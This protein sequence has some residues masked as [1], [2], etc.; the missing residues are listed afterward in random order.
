V[1]LSYTGQPSMRK[2]IIVSLCLTVL[3][4]ITP[5]QQTGAQAKAP[6]LSPELTRQLNAIRDTALA[7]DYA[8]RQVAHLTENIGPRPV[9]SPQA[10]A[11]VEY[12]AGQLRDLGLEV[13]LEEVRAPRWV[14]GLETAE[15]VDYPGHVPGVVQKI[16]VT[17]LGGNHPTANE[18]I[19]AEVLVVR[20]SAELE[21]LGGRSVAGKIVL[22][23]VPFDK[24]KAAAGF[25][26]EAYDEAVVYRGQGAV[27]AKALGA[28]AALVRSVG[29]AD[30]RIPHT[31][32]SR[33]A[34]IPAGAVSAEDADLIAHLSSQGRVRIHLTLTGE[35][36]EDV[37][38][39]NVIGDLKG[40]E[41][42]EQIVIVSGHLDSW[43]LGTGAIDDA[44]GVAVAMQAAHILK[45]LNLHPRRTLRVIA[46][47]DE[48]NFGRGHEAYARAHS[49]E[50]DNHMAA[51]ESDLG[52]GHP[53]GV[54]AKIAMAARERVKPVLQILEPI[55]ANILHPE[56][57]SPGA[58]IEPLV[59]AGVPG[60][61]ILQDSRTYF[62]YHHTP[63][64]TLG[65][66]VP[67]EL[68]ENAVV[69][70]VL[71]YALAEMPEPLPRQ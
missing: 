52:A 45:Q 53:M 65:K 50:M 54:D 16:V 29:G 46:W 35:S 49:A 36:K 38:T 61:G 27:R 20:S 58:D 6:A 66:I 11:A 26:N 22:F 68:Q 57:G 4:V 60:F 63:A 56:E 43:D 51:I 10:N 48:E 9:G 23:N 67:R 32:G 14:R 39:Y 1:R 40:S 5:A 62:N 19:T 44:A 13:R 2:T 3:T 25:A 21:S 34:G 42:A 33:A 30:F 12:V 28:V 8:Y 64:D 59:A 7:D 17:A 69:M 18:G 37:T 71:G 70:A 47:M 41:H 55:G 15:L 31:G 24:K